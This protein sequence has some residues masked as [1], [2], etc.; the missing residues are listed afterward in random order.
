MNLLC[1]LGQEVVVRAWWA[2]GRPVRCSLGSKVNDTSCYVRPLEG[3]PHSR[4]VAL[5][6]IV[7][8][9]PPATPDPEKT[10]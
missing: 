1:G 9:E 8:Y 7:G 6:D 5:K 3:N 2:R 10:S 4:W